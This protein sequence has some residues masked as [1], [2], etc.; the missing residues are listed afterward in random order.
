LLYE[1]GFN[2]LPARRK[3]II[4]GRQCLDTMQVIGQHHPPI[5]ME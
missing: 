2:E 3:I 5:D 1:Q 4:A